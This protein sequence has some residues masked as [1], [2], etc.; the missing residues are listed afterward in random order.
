VN[1]STI[2]CSYIY[3]TFVTLKTALET[4]Q[5][6]ADK[7]LDT[8][9]GIVKLALWSI[10]EVLNPLIKTIRAM[11]TDLTKEIPAFMI[12]DFSNS[13]FCEDLFKC[14]FFREYLL[15]PDSIF[16]KAIKDIFDIDEDD[17]A[18]RIQRELQTIYVDYQEFKRQLC[19]GVSLDFMLSAIT[20]LFQDF[21]SQVNK[22][23]RF[24]RRKVDSIYKQLRTYLDFLKRHGVYEL[25]DEIKAM[26]DCA[27]EHSGFC[28][29][30]ETAASF[31][32]SMLN[33]MNL[34]C[35]AANEYIIKPDYEEMCTGYMK[36][37]IRELEELANK[38]ENGLRL[39]VNPSNVRPTSDCLN[40]AGHIKGIA[41]FAMTGKASNI[42][43]YKYCKTTINDLIDAWKG[44]SN[45][46][47]YHTLD[48]I[49]EDLVFK[50][51][52]VYV[53]DEKLDLPGDGSEATIELDSGMDKR[54]M[55]R[56]I[57]IKNRI[58]SAAYALQAY[59]EKS[60]EDIVHY[61]EEYNADYTDL[62]KLDEVAVI[63]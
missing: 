14:D 41:K 36:G 63:Y 9:Y 56:A 33:K 42:P 5:A 32:Q 35:N 6:A 49:L 16:S 62:I 25:L 34:Y 4:I 18:E 23:I 45:K 2:I 26:I 55:N 52:G 48:A 3:Q 46:K 57:L 17:R 39:F 58:F 38:L 30:A 1:I 22:W 11:V 37:K 31:Y 54:S 15:N 13:A 53:G 28:A 47:E 61:F 24:L 8:I 7:L 50:Y 60:D 43:V 29:H 19:S 44:N 10:R 59:Y 40:L 27:F 21:L 51:D 20:G 12:A